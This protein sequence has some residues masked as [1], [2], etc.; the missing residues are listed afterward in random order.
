MTWLIE[1]WVKGAKFK[2][3]GMHL[4]HALVLINYDNSSSKE[5][6]MFAEKV[7]ASLKKNLM[8]TQNRTSNPSSSEDQKFWLDSFSLNL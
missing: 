5:V 6:L 8:Y 1:S 7:K 4:K 2:N 3:V